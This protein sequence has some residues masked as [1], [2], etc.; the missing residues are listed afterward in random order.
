MPWARNQS[1]VEKLCEL[2]AAISD[3][4]TLGYATQH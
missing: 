2:Q 3:V 1:D 4:L